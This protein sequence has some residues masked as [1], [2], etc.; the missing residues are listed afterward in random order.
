[1]KRILLALAYA[2]PGYFLGA[3]I[4]Y[5]LISTFSVNVHDR[6]IEAAMTGAFLT[7]PLVAFIA[8]GIGTAR[9]RKT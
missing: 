1:M 3:F 7:G 2:I 4:G 5:Y 9:S 8:L 6:D